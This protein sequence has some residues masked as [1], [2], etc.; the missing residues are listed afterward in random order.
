MTSAYV[1]CDGTHV[2]DLHLPA[3]ELRSGDYLCLHLPGP[4]SATEEK[5]LIQ[6]LT[7]GER[8]QGL[9]VTGRM[10][11]AVPPVGRRW[12]LGYFDRRRRAEDWLRRKAQVTSEQAALI[13]DR[14]KI[15]R[16]TRIGYLAW[17]P[18]NLLA[19]EAAW[20]GGAE[21][22]LFSNIGCDPMG[23]RTIRQ[24]VAGHLATCPAIELNYRF[25]MEG[26]LGRDCHAAARCIDLTRQAESVAATPAHG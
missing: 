22:V 24:S 17:N 10:Q 2:G 23:I 11:M 6:V 4:A 9:R 21:G 12:P 20:A 1:R 15:P 5:L 16:G 8:V 19:L 18:R 13:L 3:F 14:L 25:W 7:G 26:R